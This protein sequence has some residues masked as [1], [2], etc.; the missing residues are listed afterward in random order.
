M[1]ARTL[2]DHYMGGYC[3][4]S[5]GSYYNQ[6][7]MARHYHSL[8]DEDLKQHCIDWL[9]FIQSKSETMFHRYLMVEYL[10]LGRAP[11]EDEVLS[12]TTP[13][14]YREWLKATHERLL[15]QY[16]GDELICYLYLYGYCQGDVYTALV[17]LISVVELGLAFRTHNPDQIEASVS[18]IQTIMER[19][20]YFGESIG[21][22]DGLQ[23]FSLGFYKIQSK[24][25][26]PLELF[27]SSEERFALILDDLK[28]SLTLLD[29]LQESLAQLLPGQDDESDSEHSNFAYS[30]QAISDLDMNSEEN[31]SKTPDSK[32]SDQSKDTS[33]NS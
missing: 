17:V 18:R 30:S 8:G 28:E 22:L 19:W 16:D 1:E 10:Q 25:H 15:D 21:E 4:S 13:E 3:L 11:T 7:K 6:L 20:K 12:L 33:P 27:S 26:G 2:R 24:L 32:D 5:L 29:N 14:Q 23:N 31:L 9:A